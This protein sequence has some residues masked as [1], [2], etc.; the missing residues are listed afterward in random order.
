VIDNTAWAAILTSATDLSTVVEIYDSDQT[1]D[2]DGF[3]PNDAIQCFA[4]V[5]GIEFMGVEYSRLLSKIG[6]ITRKIS[7]EKNTAQVEFS[8]LTNEIS[9]FEFEHG[10]EGLIMVIRL[11]S[12]AQSVDQDTSQILFTGRCE[13][14][15]SGNR[16]SLSVTATWILGGLEVEIPRRKFSKEDQEGRVNTDPEFEG[17][18][19]MPQYGAVSYSVRVKRGGILGFFGFKKTV[20]KTLSYSSHSDLDANRPV[21]EIFGRSQILLTHIAYVDVGTNIRIRSAACEGPIE[22]IQNAR[23][24]QSLM[25]LS[26]TN[27]LE[28]YGLVGAANAI[29][30]TWPGPG[31]YSRTAGITGQ[32]SN[33]AV[34]V[35]EPA[36]DIAAVILGRLMTIPDSGGDWVLTDEWT[37]NASAHTRFVLTSPDYFRLDEN[38]I[39]DGDFYEAYAFNDQ[40]IIDR[41]L[42]DFVFATEG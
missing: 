25:P 9:D 21:P 13:K 28:T 32:C 7:A 27:Y 2:D 4:A 22:D 19:F 3:D 42:T 8:N 6:N 14:P 38:W 29:A 1:P 39:H 10:F 31:N 30:P 36:P 18:E 16:K 24:V 20:T 34:D 26:A 17:F 33:S 23:A 12:R 5:A 15:T 40:N 11:I 35:D 41:S 37:D